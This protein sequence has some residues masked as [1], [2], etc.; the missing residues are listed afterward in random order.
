M[1]ATILITIIRPRGASASGWIAHASSFCC[2]AAAM[3]MIITFAAHASCRHCR[4][5]DGYSLQY[6][7]PVSSGSE[8]GLVYSH[9]A[10]YEG[11]Q[12]QSPDLVLS[13]RGSHPGF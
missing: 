5:L 3:A 10:C 2:T 8:R 13:L 12:R 4:R 6:H 7:G 11:I 9:R 1:H